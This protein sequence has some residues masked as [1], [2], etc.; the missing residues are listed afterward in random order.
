MSRKSDL[1]F[2][3][4]MPRGSHRWRTLVE[5]NE[6]GRSGY[7]VLSHISVAFVACPVCGASVGKRCHDPQDGFHRDAHP[8]RRDAYKRTAVDPH[9][10]ILEAY[11][12]GYLPCQTG[13]KA[14]D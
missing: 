9:D 14:D 12:I 3:I 7:W 6:P 13:P 5:C 8:E 11:G 10:L 2:I 1:C 4:R